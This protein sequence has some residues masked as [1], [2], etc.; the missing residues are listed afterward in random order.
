MKGGIRM[1]IQ[2]DQD[3]GKYQISHVL[4]TEDYYDLDGKMYEFTKTN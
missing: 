4:Q 3:T 1:D 2:L